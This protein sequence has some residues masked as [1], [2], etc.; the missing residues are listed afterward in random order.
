[1]NINKNKK[2]K[3]TELAKK[4]NLSVSSVSRAL[5]GYPNISEKTKVKILKAA[6]KY[7]YYPQ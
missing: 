4:L 5:N 6:K 3:I 1:M 7:D 2:I